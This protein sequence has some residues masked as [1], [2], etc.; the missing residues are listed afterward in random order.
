MFFIPMHSACDHTTQRMHANFFNSNFDNFRKLNKLLFS[1]SDKR[2]V[3]NNN[4]SNV[5]MTL[6]APNQ[7]CCVAPQIKA[8]FKHCKTV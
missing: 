4:G 5:R 8:L 2:Q 6:L 7:L 1:L 3:N